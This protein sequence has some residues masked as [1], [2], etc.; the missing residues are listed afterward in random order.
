[1]NIGEGVIVHGLFE[2]DR[3][4]DLDAVAHAPHEVS[5]LHHHAALRVGDDVGAVALHEVWF[6]K[7]PGLAGAGTADD[8]HVF[9]PGGLGVLGT[10]IHGKGFRLRQDDVVLEYRVH[11]RLYILRSAPAGGAVFHV[12]AEFLGVLTADIHD[13]PN[14]SGEYDAYDKVMKHK[15]RREVLKRRA[16]AGNEVERFRGY[17]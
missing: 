14:D 8:Q 2:V 15:A 17:V 9:V 16:D 10:A 7:K 13:E 3:V 1:M 12:L 11:V 5:A 4:Q 6:Q